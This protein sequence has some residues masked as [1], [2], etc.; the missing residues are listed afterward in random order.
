MS[1]SP[2]KRAPRR[3]STGRGVPK[4]ASRQSINVNGPVTG[5]TLTA[6]IGNTVTAVY[7]DST[8]GGAE[9]HEQLLELGR[10]LEQLRSPANQAIMEVI[11]SAAE[12]AKKPEPDKDIV[13]KAVDFALSLAK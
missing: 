12:E 6:G 13:G 4:T 2:R 9:A 7:G 8:T 5:G 3:A 1:K 11:R 10:L